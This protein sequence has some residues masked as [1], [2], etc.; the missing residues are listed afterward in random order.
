LLELELAAAEYE[1]LLLIDLPFSNFVSSAT[2]KNPSKL[3]P[4]ES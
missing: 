4:L 2:A 1:V 3:P